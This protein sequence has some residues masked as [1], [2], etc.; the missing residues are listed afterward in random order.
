MF[1]PSLMEELLRGA[2]GVGVVYP[3]AVGAPVST[4]GHYEEAGEDLWDGNAP[5]AAQE[6]VV[7]V[8]TG[9]LAG[10]AHHRPITVGGVAYT[11][12]DHHRRRE[13]GAL[14]VIGLHRN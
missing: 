5:V 1:T 3:P 9:I 4:W 14:T 2:G 8:A 6:T 13:G 10:L 11:I 7:V 12:R